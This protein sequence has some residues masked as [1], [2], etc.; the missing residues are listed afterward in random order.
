[1]FWTEWQ[2]MWAKRDNSTPCKPAAVERLK[3]GRKVTKSNF[4][5]VGYQIWVLTPRTAKLPRK[6]GKG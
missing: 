1:M 3:T 5:M 6:G 2:Q 4:P